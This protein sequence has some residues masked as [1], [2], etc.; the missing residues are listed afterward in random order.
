M[1]LVRLFH[2]VILDYVTMICNG[3]YH[4]LQN[5]HIYLRVV[6][7]VRRGVCHE[8]CE[9]RQHLFL[10]VTAVEY[11]KQRCYLDRQHLQR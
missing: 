1:N 6:L 5:R 3:N 2:A 7:Q 9:E 8:L 10:L 4:Y 11:V